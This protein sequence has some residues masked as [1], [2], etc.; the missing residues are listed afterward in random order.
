MSNND[1]PAGLPG[2]PSVLADLPAKLR[3]HALAKLI[4]RTSKE[5]LATLADLGVD[6]RSAQSSVERDVAERVVTALLP[7]ADP[8]DASAIADEAADAPA[9]PVVEEPVDQ[10]AA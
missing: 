9:E 3:V 2:G 6:V 8:Q 7:D 4:G 10:Q 1:V 5:I